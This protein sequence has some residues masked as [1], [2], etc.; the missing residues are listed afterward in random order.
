MDF[1]GLVGARLSHSL[2]PEINKRIFEL[3]G[4]GGRTNF[5]KLLVV[6]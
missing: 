4:I 3:L 2:S 6:I 1:Y 5:L